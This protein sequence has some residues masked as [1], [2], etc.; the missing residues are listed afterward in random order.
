MNENRMKDALESIARRAVS[1]DVNLMPSIAARLERRSFMAT[2]RARPVLMIL[3]VLLTLALLSGVV[4]A[5]GRSLGYI[6]GLGV[7]D[8]NTPFHVLAEPVSQTR[9]GVT[10]TVEKAIMNADNVLLTYKVDGLTSDKFS[11]LEPLNTCFSFEELRFPGGESVKPSGGVSSNP[12][13]GGFESGFGSTNKYGPVPAGVT[14]AIFFI[15]C[16]NGALS[17]GIL[18]EN[19]ELP[20]HFVPAPPDAAL[21]MMPVIEVTSPSVT[22]MPAVESTLLPVPDAGTAN[23]LTLTRIID[24]GDNRLLY[25]EIYRHSYI[26]FGELNPP[27]PPQPGEWR[28]DWVSLDLV[29]NNGQKIDWTFP[30]DID[31]PVSDS[32][33]KLV[34]AIVVPEFAPP[35]RISQTVR[36]AIS[37]NS[38][39]T[40]AFEFD[41]RTNPQLLQEWNLNTEFQFAS[42]T[43][44][45]TR[46]SANPVR[47]GYIFSFETDDSSVNSLSARIDGYPSIEHLSFPILLPG[48]NVSRWEFY[49]YY[50]A[51][52]PKGKL[53]VIL[54]DLYL[55]G[56]TKSWTLDWQP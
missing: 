29:D 44:R 37:S 36:Y 3:L 46:I 2:L 12:V 53:K 50:S 5:L 38:Q 35:L 4:Y 52:L 1:E 32:P 15:P 39:D 54:S 45:L 6:P 28:I 16:I 40:Y 51:V 34:W 17:P 20:L 24:A 27:A 47:T 7:V 55:N 31:Q 48:S 11:F 14:D 25:G 22:A 10:V 30:R 19:W 42:H 26:L 33:Y 23:P 49:E 8:Q 43:I 41:A 56:E 18:P 21:T 9:E 13:D